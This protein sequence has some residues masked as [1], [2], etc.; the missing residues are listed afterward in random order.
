VRELLT[1][2]AAA[3]D[4]RDVLAFCGLACLAAAAALLGYA[5]GRAVVAAGAALGVVG[6]GLFYLGVFHVYLGVFHGRRQ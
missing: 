6:A 5:L 1:R 3:V 2:V 4:V